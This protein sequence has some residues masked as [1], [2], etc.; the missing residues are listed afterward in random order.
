MLVSFKL[1]FSSKFKSLFPNSSLSVLDNK[2]LPKLFILEELN[3]SGNSFLSV[4][5]FIF[6]ISLLGI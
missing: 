4:L 3:T 5:A 2:K 1:L 6:F